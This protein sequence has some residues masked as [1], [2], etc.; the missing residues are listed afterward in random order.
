MGAWMARNLLKSGRRVIVHDKLSEPVDKLKSDGA[1]VAGS[2]AEVA[3]AAKQ[4]VTMVPSSP[5]VREV[6]YGSK[7]IFS[8]VQSGSL[9]IDSSTI[10]PSVSQEI[11][12]MAEDKGAE[13]VDAPVS[14]GVLGAQKGELTFM[15]G[16]SQKAFEAAKTVLEPMGKQFFYC[17]GIGMGEAVK[18]C[19]NMAL[20]ISMIGTAET[21]NLGMKLGLDPKLLADVMNVSTG[22]SWSS[23][24]YNPV[25]GVVPG[26]PAN[27]DYEGGFGAALM[28]KDLHLCQNAARKQASPTRMGS[29]ACQIY[30]SLCEQGYSNKDFS[31]VFHFIQK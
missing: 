30:Q 7:G 1:D 28:L 8:A 5:H 27:N 6:Y 26:V 18:I 13:F 20:A 23:Q 15:M 16:G 10:D 21:M 19:N 29:L 9:L 17:G 3:A 4:I 25:P 14:G 2:P 11:G 12:E 22:Q 24:K 31:S